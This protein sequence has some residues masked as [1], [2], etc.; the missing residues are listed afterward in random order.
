M[1]WVA[2]LLVLGCGDSKDGTKPVDAGGLNQGGDDDAAASGGT[3][4]SGGKPGTSGGN[5]TSGS[6]STG[7]SGNAGRA[8]GGTAGS[9][10]RT[11]TGGAGGSAGTGVCD[12]TL[13]N[14][15][16]WSSYDVSD[17]NDSLALPQ[18]HGAIFDGQHMLFVNAASNDDYQLQ[19]DTKGDFMHAWKQFNTGPNIGGGYR[20]G[21]FDGRYVYLTPTQAESNGAGG[22]NYDTIAARYDTQ[23][24]FTA[25][26][27]WSSV[28]LTQ[29]SGAVDLTVPGYRGAAFD[30]RYVYFAPSSVGDTASGNATRYDTMGQFDDEASWTDFD[31]TTFAPHA[32]GFEGAVHAGKY[33]YYVPGSYELAARYD[34]TAPFDDEASWT[35]FDT[36][37]LDPDA[38]NFDGGVFDGRYLYFVP[39]QNNHGF[40]A[41]YD[42]QATFEDAS[43][44]SIYNPIGTGFT[45]SVS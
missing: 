18:Y 27:A 36:Q 3:S 42:T 11:G 12:Q 1:G 39:R 32:I 15:A 6:D 7:N 34:T 25:A 9:G 44:W 17:L 5:A 10:G 24:D 29:K 31:L 13:D 43:S 33:I 21:T 22:F 14:Q 38:W 40:V 2:S 8:S 20:G 35:T 16:C 30:G 37:T 45:D 28:N 4:G 41:R 26:D 19:L 23:A